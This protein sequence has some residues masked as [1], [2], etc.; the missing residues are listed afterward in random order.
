MPTEHVISPALRR[1]LLNVLLGNQPTP[2]VL[3]LGL[4]TDLPP[5]NALVELSAMEA[6]EPT[7]VPGYER[8]RLERATWQCREDPIRAETDGAWFR[9]QGDR[10]W[11]QVRGA[12]IATSQDGEGVL[13]AWNAL[14]DAIGRPVTRMLLP[15]D[16]MNV[17][18]LLGF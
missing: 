3:F 13:L 18:F 2:D 12:F 8:Q 4:L 9:N 7:G 6:R 10:N 14:E 1:L 5:E 11:P 17:P 15:G 16:V